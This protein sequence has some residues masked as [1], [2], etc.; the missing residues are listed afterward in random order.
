LNFDWSISNPMA[1]NFYTRNLG[2]LK[3]LHV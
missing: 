2:L 1:H 3:L